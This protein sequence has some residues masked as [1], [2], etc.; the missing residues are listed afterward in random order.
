MLFYRAAVDLLR[1]TLNHLAGLI[2][3]H[4]NTIGSA[5]RLLNPGLRFPS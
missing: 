4:R 5:W 2:R 3:R 1:S